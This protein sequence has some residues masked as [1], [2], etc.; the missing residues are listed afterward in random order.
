MSKTFENFEE[1]KKYRPE[2]AKELSDNLYGGAWQNEELHVFD[3]LA[4]FAEYE[5][6][7]GWY[8]ELNID[9]DWNG[10]PNLLDYINFEKLGEALENDWDSALYFRSQSGCIVRSNEGW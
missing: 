7:E 4:E 3:T 10:A 6:N 1:L 9:R 8:S 2:L 5:V